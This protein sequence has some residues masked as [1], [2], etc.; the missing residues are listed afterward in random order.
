MKKFSSIR[1]VGAVTLLIL[2]FSI[3]NVSAQTD[4]RSKFTFGIKAGANLANIYDTKSEELSFDPKLGFAGGVF[5]TI[6]LGNFLAIQ[7]EVLFS[8]KGFRTSGNVFGIPISFTRTTNFIDVPILLAVR[9]TNWL[10]LVAGPEFN[11]LISQHDNFKSG[12]LSSNQE[13]QYDN[14]NIRKNILGVNFGFDINIKQFVISPRGS[15]DFQDNKGDGTSTDPRYKNAVF[16]LT[17][18]YR[19]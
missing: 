19:F 10:S 15:I 7:P 13:K 2:I 17:L 14:D 12:N 16:Q 9:P 3:Q 4:L 8:Q 5:A 6:P 18:G 1:T 11:F